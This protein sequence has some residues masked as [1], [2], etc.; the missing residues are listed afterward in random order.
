MILFIWSIPLRKRCPYSEFFLTMFSGI[1]T[2]YGDLVRR[3]LYSVQMKE[4]TDQKN[5]EYGRFL[6]SAQR[7]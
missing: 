4:N 6:R 2:E 5:S 1:W 7:S 3:S